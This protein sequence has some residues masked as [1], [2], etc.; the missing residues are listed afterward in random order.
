[1]SA[2]A[3][4]AI[5]EINEQVAL[6][7]KLQ[8]ALSGTPALA[9]AARRR[10]LLAVRWGRASAFLSAWRWPQGST[11]SQDKI[12]CLMGDGEQQEGQVWEA[13][14]EAGH[15]KLDNIIAVIDVNRLQIDGWVKDVMEVEPLDAKYKSFGWEVL[16]V[17]ATT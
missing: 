9:K 4:R 3:S 8:L 16:R 10:S 15:Y 17:T 1:M 7:R 2:W 6:L 13:A 5:C 11:G 12:F 14:M